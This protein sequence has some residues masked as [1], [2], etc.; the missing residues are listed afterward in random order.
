M[1]IGTAIV[2]FAIGAILTFAVEV[3]STSGFN[4]NNIGVILMLVG[5]VGGVLSMLFWNSWGGFG[6]DR[7]RS[8][9][10]VE[11]DRPDVIIE[12]RPVRRTV[13]REEESF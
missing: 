8:V 2:L 7:R 9:T 4:I 1:G 5:I 3:D 10:Y 13:I 11:D 6:A 12:E